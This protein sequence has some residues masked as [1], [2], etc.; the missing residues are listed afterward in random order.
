MV[1]PAFHAQLL[2]DPAAL[3]TV[4]R[5]LAHQPVTVVPELRTTA[6]IMAAAATA[7]RMPESAAPSPPC[8]RPS[9]APASGRHAR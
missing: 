2:G 8:G 6:E 1:I 4:H 5:F 9:G 3:R 7:W